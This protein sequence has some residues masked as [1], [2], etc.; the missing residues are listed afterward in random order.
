MLQKSEKVIRQRYVCAQ[1]FL[2]VRLFVTP[3]TV[4]FQ[5]PLSLVFSRKEY[6][7]GL[8][9]PPPGDLPDPEMAPMSPA[10]LALAGGFFTTEPPYSL[11]RQTYASA[12]VKQLDPK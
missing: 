3:W 11:H 2:H 7:S 1:S 5:I 8:Q 4:T 9:F 6:W 12:F 10:Y